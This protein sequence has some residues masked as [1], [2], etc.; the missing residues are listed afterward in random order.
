MLLSRTRE[1]GARKDLQRGR[2]QSCEDCSEYE[3]VILVGGFVH[4]E[5]RKEGRKDVWS[6]WYQGHIS[7]A[8]RIEID[9]AFLS[10]G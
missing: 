7:F 8:I 9:S 6:A 1:V 10:F 2:P 5:G 4:E 3:V